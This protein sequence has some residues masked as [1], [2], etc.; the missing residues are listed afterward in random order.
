VKGLMRG[1][2][3]GLYY[4]HLNGIAHRDI[5]L[6]NIMITHEK[7]EVGITEVVPKLIDFGLSTVLMQGETSTDRY[8]TLAYCSPEVLIGAEHTVLTDIWSLGIIFHILLSGTIPFMST[9][10]N[11]YKQNI[12][13][14][15]VN[16]SAPGFHK[17]SLNAK[18]LLVRMLCN[19]AYK[20]IHI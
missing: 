19:N 16:L 14:G 15:K 13:N 9:D 20:R 12:I 5:K 11:T 8:G 18:D 7:N 10:K 2:F 4:L 3:A 1:M 6:E 17:V